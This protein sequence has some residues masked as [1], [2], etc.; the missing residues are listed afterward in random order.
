M[1]TPMSDRGRQ[2]LRTIVTILATVL[3]IAP[4]AALATN[5][6]TDVD[7][8]DFFHDA[9]DWMKDN[10]VTVG[11]NPSG[12]NTRYCPDD[13]VT[14]GQMAVFLQRLDTEDVFLRPGES[15]GGLFAVVSADGILSRGNG[16][17]SAAKIGSNPGN[18]RVI[19]DRGVGG[20]AY[21]A[22]IGQLGDGTALPGSIT[23]ASLSGNANGVYID[24]EDLNDAD[25]DRPFHLHVTC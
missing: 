7:S 14:R 23:V 1:R 6:F 5:S 24:T 11:C 3:V 12:G 21:V 25:A 17:T 22:T 15:D 18:Y 13:F 2:R 20:C 4:A 10:G 16:A 19:F 8:G 9:V